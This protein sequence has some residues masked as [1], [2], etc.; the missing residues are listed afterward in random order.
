MFGRCACVNALGALALFTLSQGPSGAGD[1]GGRNFLACLG[2]FTGVSE[3]RYT[4]LKGHKPIHVKVPATNATPR[5]SAECAMPRPP[6]LGKVLALWASPLFDW[7]VVPSAQLAS[8]VAWWSLTVRELCARAISLGAAHW[9]R[10]PS[11]L[12]WAQTVLSTSRSARPRKSHGIRLRNYEQVA[13]CGISNT[14]TIRAFIKLVR[15]MGL[16]RVM[17]PPR[18]TGGRLS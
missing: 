4:C 13:P 8:P 1:E 5:L 18:L 16:Q 6:S 17:T 3:V 9:Y 10:W 7:Q 14:R 2:I 11:L 15:P 12:P